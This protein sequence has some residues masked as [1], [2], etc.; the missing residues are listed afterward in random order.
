MKIL[1]YNLNGIRAAVRKGFLEWL[2]QVDADIVCVQE[3]KAQPDQLPVIDLE[4]LGYRIYNFSAKKKGYSG[5]A[6]FSRFEPDHVE[7]GMGMPVYD[8][9]G[10]LIRADFGDV[11]VI[12]VY[13]PSG[14]SGDERQAFKMQWLEDFQKYIDDL[15]KERPNLVISGD[16]NICH[17][18]IDIHDPIRNANSSGF[19]PEEREWIGDFLESGF[20]DSFRYFNSEPRHY[21]W[22]SFR[23]NAR[24]RNLGWRI[25]YHMV[26]N[27]LENRLK[28]AI[29]LPQAEH[30][31]H[32]PV[33]L[34]IDF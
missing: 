12:S 24:A 4:E 13:H 31:D 16:Y 22:W 30:S 9:E 25:D 8:Y 23:A 2:N 3:T 29:I 18:P 26:S 34:E 33:L 17:K 14:T 10:R 7:Y 27:P 5:V 15:K 6:I 32:C 11:S 21:T 1:T 20:I 28:R 19:L